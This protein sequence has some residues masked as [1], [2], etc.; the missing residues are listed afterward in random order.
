MKN[1]I[2][3]ILI[4]IFS[5]SLISD[6][7]SQEC[8]SFHS[9]FSGLEWDDAQRTLI[10][11]AA[12]ELN[13]LMGDVG[14]DEFTV[15]T[16]G[17]Y[18]YNANMEGGTE[19]VW[20]RFLSNHVD[21]STPHLAIGKEIGID[22][23]FK[24]FWVSFSTPTVT[25]F[26]PQTTENINKSLNES[27]SITE[28]NPSPIPVIDKCKKLVKLA[29]CDC[30]G[31]RTT[32]DI[33]L[34]DVLTFQLKFRKIAVDVIDHSVGSIGT[35]GIY[36]YAG[37]SVSF[38]G[39]N[40]YIPDQ[41]RESKRDYN[42]SIPGQIGI[43]DINSFYGQNNEWNTRQGSAGN[44]FNEAWVI[45]EDN[46]G[47]WWLYSRFTIGSFPNIT[48]DPTTQFPTIKE[49]AKTG[50][51]VVPSPFTAAI[52][53]L[54]N[55]ALDVLIQ[56]VIY[57]F[58]DE[59][60]TDWQKAYDKSS[61]WAAGWAGVSSLWPWS[62]AK[63]KLGN[64]IIEGFMSV[65]DNASKN[66]SYTVEQGLIDF[67]VGA[68][69]SLIGQVL[70]PHILDNAGKILNAAFKMISSSTGGQKTF[71]KAVAV[72]CFLL[73]GCFV[74]GTSVFTSSDIGIKPIPIEQI[75]L[76]DQVA[77]HTTANATYGLTASS[78]I[79]FDTE[80]NY[81]DPYT[82]DE[83]R[84]RDT[85]QLND[86][87]WYSVTFDQLE[88]TS[89]CQLALHRD[90][91]QEKGYFLNDTV[92]MNLLEQGISGTFNITDIKHILP[93]KVPEEDIADGYAYRPVTGLFTHISDKVLMVHFESG[94]SLGIT[95]SHPVYS[96]SAGGWK[97]AF[98]LEKD[99]I[100]LSYFGQSKVTSIAKLQG[101]H[102]VHNLEVKDLHN[103]LVGSDGVVVH[104]SCFPKNKAA[105]AKLLGIA[106]KD[107]HDWVK[108][109]ISFYKKD[110][111]YWIGK[112]PDVGPGP[113]GKLAFKVTEFGPNKGKIWEHP[114]VDFVD[115]LD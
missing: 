109:V 108:D 24:R 8:I 59:E 71:A 77:A 66:S 98:E 60:A 114:T 97:H 54:G 67:A 25:C 50:S 46:Y 39:D 41:V 58:T 94:D 11:N 68:A 85:H 37:M 91:I 69:S 74:S 6:V 32:C 75:K 2:F 1:F 26:G 35:D 79:L 12:C 80:S 14:V 64:A 49:T 76:M 55:A 102:Y 111:P 47:Q 103:F 83:Q 57:R 106:E 13:T 99:E 33:T 30:S 70:G 10:T 82:S 105:L 28:T 27:L 15:H 40:Y 81:K 42:N 19:A 90:W 107:V 4:L 48:V 9:D 78:D 18:G 36:D 16:F 53:V 115:L 65:I 45:L 89:K 7:N 3:K 73:G 84:E 72:K 38:N 101:L 63:G 95:E 43:F 112:N 110:F 34:H 21:I 56:T 52:N 100:V 96:A 51:R 44:N 61:F 22:G 62:S 29:Y 20:N 104:N 17:F 113:N 31:N 92:H 23:K 93:Q 86:R 88:G 87:D 5:F